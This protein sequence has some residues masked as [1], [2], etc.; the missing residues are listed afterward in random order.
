MQLE[1]R[2]LQFFAVAVVVAVAATKEGSKIGNDQNGNTDTNLE[3]Q[4]GAA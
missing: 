2:H 4:R 3:R 1:L